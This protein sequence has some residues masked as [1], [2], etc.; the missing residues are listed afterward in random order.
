M[1]VKKAYR[2]IPIDDLRL[3]QR[4]E[5]G[6]DSRKM[7]QGLTASMKSRGWPSGMLLPVRTSG[8]GKYE[9]RSAGLIFQAARDAGLKV[10]PCVICFD[11]V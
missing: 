7:L 2:S 6:D 10:I 5:M 9:I 3:I 11:A 8:N 1:A 4:S